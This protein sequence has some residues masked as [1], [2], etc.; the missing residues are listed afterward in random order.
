MPPSDNFLKDVKK[1]QK[2]K[3]ANQYTSANTLGWLEIIVAQ[4]KT[5]ILK[6][7]IDT[8]DKSIIRGEIDL[9]IAANQ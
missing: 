6:I 1:Q 5:A 3:K 8:F 7:E 4:A 9:R 2:K